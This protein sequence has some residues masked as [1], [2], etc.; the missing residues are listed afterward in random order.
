LLRALKRITGIVEEIAPCTRKIRCL[1]R[2]EV[3]I[4]GFCVVDDLLHYAREVAFER[5]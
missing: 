4:G 3:A 2:Q 1:Q 5:L